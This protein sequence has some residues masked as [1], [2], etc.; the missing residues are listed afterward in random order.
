MIELTEAERQLLKNLSAEPL[1]QSI[2]HKLEALGRAVPAFD[3]KKTAP[4]Q[5]N[6]EWHFWSG[7]ERGRKDVIK[8]LSND[9]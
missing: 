8:G 7:V 4:D 9:R 3:P 1:W 5:Q 6:A 2:L